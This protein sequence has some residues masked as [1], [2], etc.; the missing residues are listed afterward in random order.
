MGR[1]AQRPVDTETAPDPRRTDLSAPRCAR[2]GEVHTEAQST[3]MSIG[4]ARGPFLVVGSA[5][6]A[7]VVHTKG[8]EARCRLAPR[9][10]RSW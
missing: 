10:A 9:L 2:P 1:G 3:E 7:F 5:P 8:A 4:S 6:R